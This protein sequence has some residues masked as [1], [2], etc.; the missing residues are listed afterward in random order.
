MRGLAILLVLVFHATEGLVQK[1]VLGPVFYVGQSGVDIFFI[2][3]GFII[4]Y[5][6]TNKKNV[7]GVI[8]FLRSRIKR[9]VPLYWFYTIVFSLLLIA[10]PD[11][12]DKSVFDISHLIHSLFFI[13]MPE[14]SPPI[15]SLGWTLNYEIYFYLIFSFSIF[16][17]E[18]IRFVLVS[19]MLLA[20]YILSITMDLNYFYRNDVVFEFLLGI[21]LYY[22]FNKFSSRYKEV[23]SSSVF[24]IV[25][26]VSL[27]C[28]AFLN[29][30][31]RFLNFGILSFAVMLLSLHVNFSDK[32]SYCIEKIG[33]ASYSIYLSHALSMPLILK[34]LVYSSFGFY[35]S[36]VI[37]IAFSLIIG[38]L[39]YYFLERKLFS[40][41]N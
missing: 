31:Y 5:S 17:R 23:C 3:S 14:N 19:V 37:S 36:V 25:L 1:G 9:I 40:F 4:F 11:K 21:L 34:I 13:P 27:I 30:Q 16:F 7:I 28:M 38:F 6:S 2:I 15:V 24:L 39:S 26:I 8:T 10:F 32:L 20:I 22:Y 41:N 35:I 33:E 18:R 12:F 29:T